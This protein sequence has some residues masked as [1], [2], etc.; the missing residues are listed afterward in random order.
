MSEKTEKPTPKKIRDAREKGQVAK[1][2]EIVSLALLVVIVLLFWLMSDYYLSHLTELITLPAKFL[3][4]PWQLALSEVGKGILTESFYLL[5][6]IFT[7]VFITGILSNNLQFGWLFSFTPIKPELKKINPIEGAKKIFAKKNLV[8]FLK[9]VIKILTLSIA[10]YWVIRANMQDLVKIVHCG[11]ECSIPLLGALLLQLFIVVLVVFVILAVLDMVY[12]KHHHEKELKMSKDEV[13]REYK[14]T[15][16]NPEIKQQRKQIHKDLLAS[17]IVDNVN[18]ANLLVTNPTHFAVALYYKR[19]ETDLPKVTA[20]GTDSL[21][22]HMIKL[23][24]EANVPVLRHVWLARQLSAKVGES[25]FV[26]SELLAAVAEVIKWA[27]QIKE[28]TEH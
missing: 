5:A 28:T 1:S 10:I 7:V 21:A 19:G 25:E 20:K 22:Q 6:P 3:D 8:E 26:A 9:S 2:K 23:A 11:V 16:G 12:E 24:E 27:E 17:N 13:K 14:E 18:N 4:A 15:E